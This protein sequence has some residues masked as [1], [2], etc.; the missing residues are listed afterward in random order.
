M[1]TA[2][3]PRFKDGVYDMVAHQERIRLHRLEAQD[4][5]NRIN[6]A[7]AVLRADI[8]KPE[9]AV[10]CLHAMTAG[11]DA[12]NKKNRCF[13]LAEAIDAMTACAD[14]IEFGKES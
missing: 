13:R 10:L 3:L 8:T 12:F 1:N 14:L 7:L 6:A 9:D 5:A 11:M 2:T 4:K